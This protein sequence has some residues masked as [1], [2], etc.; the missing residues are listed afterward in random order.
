M[1][2]STT[3]PGYTYGIEAVAKSPLTDEDFDRLKQ[4]T[5]FTEEDVK[6]LRLAGEVLDDQG[7]DLLD[8]WYGFVAS[9]PFLVHEFSGP[10]GKPD[11]DYLAA[12]RRRFGQWVRDTTKVDYDR[13]W[14]D[15]QHEIGLRHTSAKKNWTDGV[16]SASDQ[17][18]MCEPDRLHHPVHRDGP[19]VPGE[20]GTPP[21]A[22]GGDAPGLDE[23]CH[24]PGGAL[25]LRLHRGRRRLYR[26]SEP[27][28]GTGAGEPRGH[29]RGSTMPNPRNHTDP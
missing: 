13:A 7:E 22:G 15:Y 28:R 11:S 17:V 16:Q 4:A 21:R 29:H 3:I 27:L 19:A 9:H 6:A 20:E 23:G 25:E 1:T 24:P 14:L 5:L 12:V 18:P 10:D 2:T 8:V 26:D